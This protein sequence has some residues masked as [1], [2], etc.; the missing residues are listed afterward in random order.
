MFLIRVGGAKALMFCMEE[1]SNDM[2][3][4]LLVPEA[5]LG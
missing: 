3:A 5:S 4:A 1:V 2:S